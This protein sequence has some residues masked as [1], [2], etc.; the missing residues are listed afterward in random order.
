MTAPPGPRPADRDLDRPTPGASKYWLTPRAA[1]PHPSPGQIAAHSGSQTA[2][3]SSPRAASPTPTR[4]KQATDTTI[5]S[6]PSA[7]ALNEEALP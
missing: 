2:L 4:P 5:I 6:P 3:S 1:T 7:P